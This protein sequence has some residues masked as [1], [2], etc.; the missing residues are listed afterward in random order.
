LFIETTREDQ[1][2]RLKQTLH[3]GSLGF[4]RPLWLGSLGFP[5]P[6]SLDTGNTTGMHDQLTDLGR[7]LAKHPELLRLLW[8]GIEDIHDLKHFSCESSNLLDLIS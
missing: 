5:R 7:D 4:L 6:L 1:L 2:K 8:R 3:K